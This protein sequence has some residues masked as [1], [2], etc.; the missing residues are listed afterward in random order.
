M[1]NEISSRNFVVTL[2]LEKRKNTEPEIRVIKKTEK[3]DKEEKLIARK[4]PS[5]KI[6]YET[7]A[8]PKIFEKMY[9]EE[10]CSRHTCYTGPE[11]V[12][13][14][15]LAMKPCNYSP[16][17]ALDILHRIRCE[18][19]VLTFHTN[20]PLQATSDDSEQAKNKKKN[21]KTFFDT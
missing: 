19:P 11:S 5:K 20:T 3:T 17:V 1:I 2:P 18:N 9:L 16:T 14:L 10:W 12:R 4:T 21:S 8:T 13:K 6:T 15:P 7:I